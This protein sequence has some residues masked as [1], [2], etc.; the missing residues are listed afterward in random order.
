M[1][2]GADQEVSKTGR[3]ERLIRKVGAHMTSRLLAA[4]VYAAARHR[5]DHPDK[6]AP[7]NAEAREDAM[8]LAGG[9][10]SHQLSGG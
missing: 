5:F 10:F 3:C 4:H 7:R 9:F 8:R 2:A 6:T 1:I